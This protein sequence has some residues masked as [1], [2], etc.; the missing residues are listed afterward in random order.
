M[1]VKCI[2]CSFI[3]ECVLNLKT[4]K[5]GA[6]SYFR[7]ESWL[8]WETKFFCTGV[9]ID[10]LQSLLG[11]HPTLYNMDVHLLLVYQH[12]IICVF[13]DK[14]FGGTFV[15]LLFETLWCLLWMLRYEIQCILSHFR[16]CCC[17]ID[18]H[19]LFCKVC[20][21]LCG[22]LSSLDAYIWVVYSKNS[23]FCPLCVLVFEKPIMGFLR[24]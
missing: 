13:G 23:H 22:H 21:F 2:H 17:C 3:L 20:G 6:C 18:F 19:S 5:T 9:K 10:P 1:E 14:N 8:W 24:C 12:G 11:V 4:L 16:I 15:A 7:I